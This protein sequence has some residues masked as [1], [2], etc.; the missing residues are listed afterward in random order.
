MDIFKAI[1]QGITG[2]YKEKKQTPSDDLYEFVSRDLLLN[3][4]E[5][6]QFLVDHAENHEQL[7]AVHQ[8][9][10]NFQDRVDVYSIPN[11]MNVSKNIIEKKGGWS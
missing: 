7:D 6:L 4:S 8:H 10:N 11:Y 9:M 3:D 5:Y 2:Y 1:V